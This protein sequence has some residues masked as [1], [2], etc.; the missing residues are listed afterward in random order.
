M[1]DTTPQPIQPV[2]KRCQCGA[3]YTWPEWVR[4]RWAFE[5][6]DGTELSEH[7][8]CPCGSTIAIVIGQSRK[9]VRP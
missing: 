8:Q 1:T 7:R 3:E 9:V 4:L 6:D 5:L 2:I